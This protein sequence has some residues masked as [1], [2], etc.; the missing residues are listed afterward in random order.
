M[1]EELGRLIEPLARRFFGEPNR[2]RSTKKE[3]RFGSNGSK[4]IDLEKGTFFDHEAGF[5][6]GVLELVR[7]EVPTDDP[8]G[9]LAHEGMIDRPNGA[10]RPREV[11]HYDYRDEGETVLFQVV[12]FE[13]KDFRQRVPDP[14]EPRGYRWTVKGIRQVPYRLPELKAGVAARKLIFVVEGEKDADRLAREGAVATT[15]AGGAGKWKA[16]L[17]VYFVGADVIVIAD[18][19]PQARDKDGELTWH[20]DGRPRFPGQ[21]HAHAVAAH[22]QPYAARVRLLDLGKR[23]PECPS[24]GDVSDWFAGRRSFEELVEL[25]GALP[26][27]Q[28]EQARAEA[29]VEPLGKPAGETKPIVPRLTDNDLAR[30]FAER[31]GKEFG[32]ESLNDWRTY[33]ALEKQR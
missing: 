26:A 9:W 5:G 14:A 3:I 22:L 23:W 25:I 7:R 2:S 31:G 24:K 29:S 18:N 21:D 30:A 12:R 17:N 16:E 15:N 32:F 19:D 6:G 27:W 8:L 11:A 13:P 20:P 4:S 33:L 10:P 1:A 28:P